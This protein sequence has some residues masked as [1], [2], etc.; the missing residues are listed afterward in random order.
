MLQ[1]PAA[2]LVELVAEGQE[3]PELAAAGVEL[4]G[5]Q[6]RM[7]ELVETLGSLGTLE[8]APGLVAEAAVAAA[9]TAAELELQAL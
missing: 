1:T 9:P 2:N 8:L 4:D 3:E 6:A 5:A 7:A